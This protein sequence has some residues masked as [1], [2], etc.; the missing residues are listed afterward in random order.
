MN[1]ADDT[2][3]SVAR[4]RLMAFTLAAISGLLAACTTTTAQVASAPQGDAVARACRPDAAAELVG[5]AALDDAPIQ[6]RTGAELIRRIAPGDAVTHDF[7]ENRVTLAID[8]AG[9]VVLATCG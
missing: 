6:Q 1:E 2:A 9:K 3:G 7:R 8:S 5:Q 4:M